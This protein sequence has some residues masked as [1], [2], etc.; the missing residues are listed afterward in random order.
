[1]TINTNNEIAKAVWI[2][3]GTI[4]SASKVGGDLHIAGGTLNLGESV[5]G[6]A[7][8]AG[9]QVNLLPNFSVAKNAYIAGGNVSL[10]GN[11]S[12]DV[13]VRANKISINPNAIIKG[14]FDYYSQQEI[15]IPDGA[16]IG[17]IQFHKIE[18]NAGN[19]GNKGFFGFIAAWWF[20]KM[21]TL[22]AATIIFFLL[23]KKELTAL[24]GNA[25]SSFWKELLRGFIIFVVIPAASLIAAL[26]VIGLLPAVILM[27]LYVFM[28]MIAFPFS[29][30]L[31]GELL[32]K[33]GI[34]GKGHGLG[35]WYVIGGA[36][37]I[38]LIGFIPFIGWL[39]SFAII[40]VAFGAFWN[41]VYANIK[42]G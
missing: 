16:K 15:T 28:F 34:F 17:K 41:R 6:E 30:I 8:I 27:A 25:V 3:G 7:V 39:V 13:S 42:I 38:G 14:T 29:C 5:M 10:G 23:W 40:L 37:A 18:N 32:R 9:G 36:I 12:G 33:T 21:M 31:A 35:I 2:V 22:L 20:I 11:Y 24:A 19:P 4:N 26:T 1:G